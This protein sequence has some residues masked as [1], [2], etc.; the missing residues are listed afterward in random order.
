MGDKTLTDI[1]RRLVQYYRAA[2]ADIERDILRLFDKLTEESVDGIIRPNDLYKYGR[3]YDLQREIYKRLQELGEQEIAMQ[4]AKYKELYDWINEN[5][6]S[7]I[8]DNAARPVW[9]AYNPVQA[10]QIINSV[11][12]SD[13][14]YWSD[15]VWNNK[16]ALQQRIEKGLV[17]C[18]V[19]G[20]K[21][22]ELVKQ[23]Q[24]D[25]GV[26]Y[27]AAERIART[28]LTHVQN[29]AAAEIY[30]R[31]GTTHYQFVNTLDGR[32]CPACRGLNGKTFAFAD[33]K[34]GGNFPPVHPNCR[35][36]IVAVINLK[37]GEEIV[38]VVRGPRKK[39]T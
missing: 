5:M 19:R 6:P 32:T 4:T 33:K 25:F 18:V 11:W 39:K 12:C 34:P 38:P 16:T 21:K 1:N 3:Y 28:E 36:R 9:T 26:G 30:T 35:G 24:K 13:G 17:D 22:S 20:A 27:N 31:A 10:E 7:A 23:L 37:N 2:A 14:L 29:E 8:P 15:R